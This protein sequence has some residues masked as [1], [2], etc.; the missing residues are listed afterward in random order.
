MSLIQYI[1]LLS[2]MLLNYFDSLWTTQ[3]KAI[4]LV[5]MCD[6]LFQVMLKGVLGIWCLHIFCLLS[7][8][9]FLEVLESRARERKWRQLHFLC[10]FRWYKFPCSP[11]RKKVRKCNLI[12]RKCPN[13]RL[14]TC[15][16][17]NNYQK[18][19]ADVECHLC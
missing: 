6:L 14:L 8:F 19:K 9:L 12:M 4:C 16:L 10:T 11:V 1:F 5:L 2:I 17:H 7:L 18:E 13:I 3:N 15:P